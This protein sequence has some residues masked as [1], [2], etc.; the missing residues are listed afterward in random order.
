MKKYFKL[1]AVLLALCLSFSSC[2]D[3]VNDVDAIIGKWQIFELIEE[4]AD[5]VRTVYNINTIGDDTS[6]ACE[7]ETLFEFRSN[8]EFVHTRMCGDGNTFT[9]T[10]QR[11]G[12]RLLF[13]NVN[14]LVIISLTDTELKV[15]DVNLV[16]EGERY[17]MR[18]RRL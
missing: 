9:T 2:E 17:I 18:L 15:E 4:T 16:E 10:W 14:N 3:K 8:G 1:T 11:D 7:F 12:N 5:G 6:F 13:N